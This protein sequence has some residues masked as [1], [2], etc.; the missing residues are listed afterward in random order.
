MFTLS[1][2]LNNKLTKPPL[3]IDK[4]D[5]ALNFSNKFLKIGFA[6]YKRL[7]SDVLWITTLLESDLKHYSRKDLN[8]WMFL[9]FNSISELD[10]YFLQNYLFGSQYLSIIKDDIEGSKVLFERGLHYYPNNYH[11]IFNAAFL[12]A[13][14]LGD[15][16][17]ALTTL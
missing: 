7:I 13:F 2:A 14:E 3:K 16:E 8:N 10:E 4:Q 12:Y 1:G 11:L 15:A 17:K 6:G 5:S 9:R